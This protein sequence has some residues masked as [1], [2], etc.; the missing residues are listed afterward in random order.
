VHLAAVKPDSLPQTTL[1]A[2]LLRLP[3]V[4]ERTGMKKSTIYALMRAHQFP[5][6]VMV[7]ARSVAWRA[8]EVDAWCE[9]RPTK[10]GSAA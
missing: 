1:S 9:S 6:P 3:Y 7:G 10:Q 8:A 5:Q 4:E 2:R